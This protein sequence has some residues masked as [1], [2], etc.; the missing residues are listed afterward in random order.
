MFV[1]CDGT[2]LSSV[3]LGVLVLALLL[4]VRD[5]GVGAA[6]LLFCNRVTSMAVLDRRVSLEEEKLVN[7]CGGKSCC[8]S[9]G[10]AL[11]RFSIG[12]VSGVLKNMGELLRGCSDD[13]GIN[14]WAELFCVF[15]CVISASEE[16]LFCM[17]TL[18]G[19][20]I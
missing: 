9:G 12:R 19:D 3:L 14:C 18:G 8:L 5:T 20:V 2:V 17:N 4:L 16:E 15:C 6:V 7:D 11:S 13:I 10:N 1:Y